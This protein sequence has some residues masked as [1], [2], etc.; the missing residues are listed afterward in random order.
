[1]YEIYINETKLVLTKSK[2]VH[3]S[4]PRADDTLVAV[5]PGKPK[6]LLNY[7]DMMEKGTKFKKIVLHCGDKKQ[8]VRDFKSLFTVVKAG[9]G[10][11]VNPKD[12]VLFIFRRGYWDLPKGKI[13]SDE[14]N[15]TGAIR[16]VMEE[17]GVKNVK[18]H[19]RLLKTRH[20]YK[21]KSGQR[22]I[23]LTYWYLMTTEDQK[24]IP[25][26]QEDITKATW[27]SLSKF[28]K[29]GK[30]VYKNIKEVIEAYRNDEDKSQ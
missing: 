26:T 15:K 6:F 28:E 3:K 9:G 18:L 12:E 1:M 23:K 2:I 4:I 8:L 21:S 25:Q 13:E 11:V 10:L 24:L 19:N 30:P 29:E 22:L 16:E 7:I 5:Y 17:T 20:T 27:M 14:T